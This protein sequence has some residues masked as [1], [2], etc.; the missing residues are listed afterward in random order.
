ML[1]LR[2][3]T[4]GFP[5]GRLRQPP[6][7]LGPPRE[8]VSLP[9]QA[10]HPGPLAFFRTN[11]LGEVGVGENAT[12]QVS[13]GKY[14][15]WL[16]ASRAAQGQLARENRERLDTNR[17]SG[18]LSLRSILGSIPA[19]TRGREAEKWNFGFFCG[20]GVQAEK[21]LGW[22]REG[23]E[24]MGTLGRDGREE[25]VPS[26]RASGYKW[27]LCHLSQGSG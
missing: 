26:S 16:C 9:P 3:E 1:L 5:A 18:H 22:D 19:A 4:L 10:L 2:S 25:I 14:R 21:V 24:R 7:Q 15:E 11:F 23:W 20:R 17:A 27:P 12:A 13:P 8:R 6:G